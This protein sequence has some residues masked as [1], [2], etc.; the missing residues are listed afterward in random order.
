[1]LPE[2]RYATLG[3]L[4]LAYQVVGTGPPDLVMSAGSFSHTDALWEEPGAERFLR[5]LSTFARLIRFDLAGGS[6][7]DRLPVGATR[8][9]FTDQ[10]DTV[11]T[12]AGSDRF[13]ILASLDAGPSALSYV[14]DHPERV[15]ALVIYNS[16][17]RWAKGEGYD[18]GFDAAAA[19]GLRAMV[20][21][22]WGTDALV[23]T[24]VPSR[25]GDPRF[26]AWYAKYIRS[27]G[28]PNDIIAA[29][30]HA[31]AVDATAALHRIAV[32]TLVIHRRD[33]QF[34][35]LS[36]GAYIA[37]HIPGA[38][39]V[40]VPGADGPLYWETP[41][42]FLDHLERFV[43]GRE[44]SRGMERMLLTFL[45]TDIVEST[46][47]AE[48]LGD[49]DWSTVLDLHYE[50]SER[51]AERHGGSVINRTG[52]GVLCTFPSP[53]DALHAA[54]RLRDELASMGIAIRSGL[55]V[56]EISALRENISGLAVNIAARVMGEAAPGEILA[57]RTVRDLLTGAPTS[58]EDAG[59]HTLRGIEE[60]WQ[61]Y[62]VEGAWRERG[63]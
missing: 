6:G 39:L 13:A 56:G 9:D 15:T 7:S 42:V 36:H 23:E 1:M 51:V 58:F 5:Q 59:M 33:Y 29:L 3:E 43:A 44:R 30:E 22:S 18:I 57:S 46:R 4:R 25:S 26:R 52:D 60:P 45:F 48:R 31:L 16:T 34:L 27:L 28:T 62:R 17:S 32:P 41:D 49:R 40:V 11:L 38:Q 61:L 54:V 63:P 53:S 8:P 21:G 24:N 2:T 35:P 12:A 47:Q 55:H 37:E 50:I 19:R 20:E 10:L 14:A